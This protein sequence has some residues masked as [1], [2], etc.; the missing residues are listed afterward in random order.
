MNFQQLKTFCT[1]LNERSMTAA[2]QKLFLTQPA[3]SQQIRHLEESIGVDLFVRGVRK[4]K[5][6]FQGQM[7]YEYAQRI[8]NLADQAELAIQ[9]M[10]KGVK[11]PLR[12]GT[13]NSIG[14]H[15][16]GATF[17]IF[18]KSNKQVCLQLTYAPGHQLLDMLER[19]ELDLA[20]LPDA[21]DEY[22][23]DPKDCIKSFLT[24]TEIYLV[25]STQDTSLPEN[26]YLKDINLRSLVMIAGE[27]PKFENFIH[28]EFKR[29]GITPKTV[30]ESSNI[31]TL[32]RVIE[33]GVGWGFLP[34]HAIRKQVKMGRLKRIFIKDFQ[35]NIKLF[36]YC[37]KVRAND[38]TSEVFLKILTGK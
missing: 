38:K 21:S 34:S 6:T 8:L 35:Y 15:T 11:G 18:L 28:K 36:C 19:G 37:S 22:K 14:L 7:L 4:I 10:G 25:A 17:S 23:N 29:Q 27:Y 32:K 2:A 30:F 5:P 31:G 13:L 12:I 9:T 16:I 1:V 26:I 20:V 3:V 33:T 24:N